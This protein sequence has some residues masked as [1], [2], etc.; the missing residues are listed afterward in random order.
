MTPLSQTARFLLLP[1]LLTVAAG[2]ATNPASGG[3]D[4][5]LMS[6]VQEVELG[7]QND[8]QIRKQYGVYPDPQLQAYVDQVGKKLAAQSHRP[9]LSYH[10]TVLDSDEVNAFA[11]PGGYV[12]ITRGILAYLNSEAELAA[13]L[14][15]EIGHVTARHGVRQY[16]AATAANIGANIVSVFVPEL[17]SVGGQQLLNVLGGALLSG[18][19]RDHELEADRLGAEYIARIGYDPDAMI[20][21]VGVLKNQEEFEKKRASAEGRKPRIYH[22]VFASHPSAD[23]R[24]QQVV[25]EAH[26]HKSATTSRLARADYLRHLD[27]VVYGDNETQG[28]RRGRNFYH[29]DLNFA[30]SFPEGW[31]IENRPD[32]ILAASP[33]N[34]A[35]LQVK[36]E[37][38]QGAATPREF[39]QTR[40]QLPGA[41]RQGAIEGA[42]QPAYTAVVPMNT[43]FGR[44]DARASVVFQRD[45][46]FIFLGTA[47]TDDRFRAA[48]SDFLATARS[49]H[50]LTA[51]EQH[52]ARSLRLQVREARPGDSF[53]GLAKTSALG[54]DAE[55]VLR[56]VNDRFPA[57]EPRPGEKIKII[58]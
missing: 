29:R 49:L 28:I 52:L 56:L 43:P 21:V 50:P 47:R 3:K 15:H 57:G 46:A 41:V 53:A 11:L 18:Y 51:E 26:K 33:D 58:E 36:S 12:Y 38:A 32:S 37:P 31:H 16:T 7:R 27:G 1:V 4:F 24:L 44:R 13:V 6:E 42:R 8:P 54:K 45:S 10:F 19:G 2:C 35:L 55:A 40:L 17:G 20:G 39:M 30:L 23:Q 25:A 5:V 9:G 14:G 48:D 34:Q 22:G